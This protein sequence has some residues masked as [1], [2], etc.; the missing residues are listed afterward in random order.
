MF[1]TNAFNPQYPF[2]FGLSYTS[3]SYDKLKL[4][5]DTL[6]ADELLS[7]S[8]ELTNT[9]EV[10]GQEVVQLFLTDL[11]ASITPPVRRLRA[12]D[13]IFLAAGETETVTFELKASDFA[14]VGQ[15][16]QWINESGWFVVSIGGEKARFYYQLE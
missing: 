2:G 8:I 5:T 14:F 4:S 12:F 6:R 11:V 10:D 3:F 1:D 13:K 9:G 15:N 7:L 16:D